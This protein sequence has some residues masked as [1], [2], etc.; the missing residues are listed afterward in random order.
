MPTIDDFVLAKKAAMQ[1][2]QDE[3][4]RQYA[5]ID[6]QHGDSIAARLLKIDTQERT[7]AMLLMVA[8]APPPEG[9]ASI[10]NKPNEADQV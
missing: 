4:E 6:A 9:L 2:I 3:A 8:G 1:I 7:I 5:I 10:T